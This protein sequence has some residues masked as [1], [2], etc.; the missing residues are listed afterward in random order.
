V[1][2]VCVL[3]TVRGVRVCLRVCICVECGVCL[4]VW[5][6]V[7]RPRVYYLCFVGSVCRL[8]VL[9][10]VLSVYAC[11]VCACVVCVVRVVC[12]VFCVCGARL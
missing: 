1:R 5:S 10:R 6:C 12:G 3:C 8:S 2:G 4:R 9:R 11:G 7:S